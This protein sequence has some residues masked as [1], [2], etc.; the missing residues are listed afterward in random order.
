M[1]FGSKQGGGAIRKAAGALAAANGVA[2]VA[3]LSLFGWRM[4]ASGPLGRISAILL[5]VLAG[6][7]LAADVVGWALVKHGG[8]TKARTLGLWAVALSTALAAALLFAAS[9]TG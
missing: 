9:W 7:G 4:L 8:R 5:A 6:V 3:F 2:H 1:I